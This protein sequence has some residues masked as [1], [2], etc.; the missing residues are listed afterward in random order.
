[1]QATGSEG[2]PTP[3]AEQQVVVVQ[4]E[5]DQ[6]EAP[7]EPNA[8]TEAE[9]TAEV[10]QAEEPEPTIES[11]P[12]DE[13]EQTRVEQ[14]E[15]QDQQQQSAQPATEP[16]EADNPLTGFI[17]PIRGACVTEFEGH[18]PE[19]PR[20]YRNDGVHEGLDFYQWASC[21]TI[22]Y[23]TEIVA[24]KAG[25]VIR[26]DVDYVDITPADWERFQAA[27]WEGEDVL[28]ELRGRQVWIDHGRG[29]VTR[30]A[31]LSAIV[32]GIVAGVEVQ[33]GQ[34]IGY[35]GES[36]QREVY[37]N[38]GT[39]IHLHFEIRVGNGWLGQ[40]KPPHE[41]RDLYLKAF[42]RAD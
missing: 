21:T 6:P 33:Q 25:V 3:A 13:Q 18:L 39:D 24:A 36:G 7:A 29:I 19:A 23:G 40:G 5:R 26:A 35:P 16:D 32:D 42:G 30:Y 8:A 31:H 1:M 38:P 20:S 27:N 15:A 28:D 12:A 37:A 22:D 17:V 10:E 14:A 4:Q 41:A 11:G 2:A 34:V 9:A